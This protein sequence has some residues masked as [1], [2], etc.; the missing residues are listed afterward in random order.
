MNND[1]MR[2]I[3]IL[4]WFTLWFLAL[5]GVAVIAGCLTNHRTANNYVDAAHPQVVRE[6][7][8]VLSAPPTPG[9][10]PQFT[11]NVT[12]R[13]AAAIPQAVAAP[14]LKTNKVSIVEY[15]PANPGGD[16]RRRWMLTQSTHDLRFW[17]TVTSN[18]QLSGH[19]ATNNFTSTNPQTWFRTVSDDGK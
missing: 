10:A 6:T 14:P 13:F 17:T 16:T 12:T 15:V 9:K 4:A 5:L 11:T 7:N 18:E 19:Y 8:V 3:K 2:S 1:D